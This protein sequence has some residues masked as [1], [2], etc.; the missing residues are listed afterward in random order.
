MMPQFAGSEQFTGAIGN[1]RNKQYSDLAGS[2]SERVFSAVHSTRCT[3][4]RRLVGENG[5][6]V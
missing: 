5:L 6:S 1:E 2:R 3:L 4:P